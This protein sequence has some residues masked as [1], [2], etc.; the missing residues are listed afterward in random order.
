MKILA[1][2]E[3]NQIATRETLEIFSVSLLCYLSSMILFK[4]HFTWLAWCL[5]LMVLGGLANLYVIDFNNRR[6]PVLNLSR[7]GLKAVKKKHP[8]RRFCRLD[9]N[10]KLP[11]L[12]D[13]FWIGKNIYSLGDFFVLFSVFLVAPYSVVK[14]LSIFIIIVPQIQKM[15]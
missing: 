5:L 15:L 8:T 9:R 12:A 11:W 7:R 3:K 10:T 4:H 1:Y 13:R 14:I 2:L 6:M